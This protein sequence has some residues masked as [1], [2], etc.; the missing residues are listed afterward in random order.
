M[1]P[2]NSSD[3]VY[4]DLRVLLGQTMWKKAKNRTSK[5]PSMRIH[6]LLECTSRN[7][8][9]D[10]EENS[11]RC[12]THD[13]FTG[14][15]RNANSIYGSGSVHMDYTYMNQIAVG[16]DANESDSS[17]DTDD[18]LGLDS[19]FRELKDVRK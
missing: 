10:V 18:P 7:A 3:T 17:S 11:G 6:V 4:A 9:Y 19:F 13:A 16:C 15:S 12:M 8:K 14:R 5:S 2:R 1:A